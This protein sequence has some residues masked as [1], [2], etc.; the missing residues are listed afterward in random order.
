M[1]L[2]IVFPSHRDTQPMSNPQPRHIAP[3]FQFL[4]QIYEPNNPDDLATLLNH[5]K[6]FDRA[7]FAPQSPAL[8]PHIDRATQN[9]AHTHQ[10]QTYL[11]QLRSI[12]GHHSSHIH[13]T[14][15][16][17]IP[18]GLTPR[19]S[20]ILF[21]VAQGCTNAAIAQTLS[22]HPTTIKTHL[23]HINQKLNATSRLSAVTI[24][25]KQLGLKP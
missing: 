18:I 8:Q 2:M 7:D 21:H 13:L 3:I 11:A 23:A 24:A 15:T 17:F 1:S 10:L 6:S 25:L 22:V 4:E 5:P 19:Q 20:E 14:K 9:A 16:S 12:I